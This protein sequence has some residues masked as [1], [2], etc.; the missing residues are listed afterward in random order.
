MDT[1]SHFNLLVS[2]LY[3]SFGLPEPEPSDLH[4]FSIDDSNSFHIS[5]KKK[6]ET[7]VFSRIL[8]FQV[9]NLTPED[10]CRIL[11]MTGFTDEFVKKGAFVDSSNRISFWIQS[12]LEGLDSTFAQQLI[13]ELLTDAPLP[14]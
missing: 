13:D 1:I 11:G 14:E 10:Y 12:P 4:S 5:L 6:T 8:D 3:A 2:E 7:I 9:D